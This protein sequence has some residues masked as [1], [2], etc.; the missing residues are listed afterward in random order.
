MNILFYSHSNGFTGSDISLREIIKY[1]KQNSHNIFLCLPKSEN[2]SY[3]NSLGIK[4]NNILFLKPMIWHKSNQ[5]NIFKKYF[6]LLYIIFKTNGGYFYTVPKL[7]FFLLINKI[8]IVH[9]NS[10]VLIDG[11]IAAKILNIPHVQHIR[12][13]L[14]KK[15][16]PFSFP[17][18][19]KPQ[20]FKKI[21]NIL[22][23][24]IIF[25][26]NF[27]K[28]SA[29]NLFPKEKLTVIP[30]SF[31]D[32]LY[33]DRLI[34]T[35]VRVIGLVAN[36]TSPRKNHILFL[37]IANLAS[38]KNL[39]FKFIIFGK[40]PN[41]YNEYYFSLLEFIRINKLENYVSFAGQVTEL[42][43]IYGKIDVLVHTNH[44]ETF[45][46]IYIESM[47]FKVPVISVSSDAAIELIE[48]NINGVL[49]DS[50]DE[51]IFLDKILELK[52]HKQKYLKLIEEGYRFS[53]KYKSSLVNKEIIN[54][55]NKII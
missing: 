35:S 50:F 42:K 53:L 27:S 29:I 23:K 54:I 30:N 25:N 12:E 48:N 9:S 21:M 49:I 4:R 34:K 18:Q 15:E 38:R 43:N 36:I 10:F 45:G 28:N 6:E 24:K 39:D 31:P 37:K 51:N 11:V 32:E 33:N 40:L 52:N 55:Y 1:C 16:S 17:L 5:K 3:I 41:L 47:I 13:L 14:N 2:T 19:D 8:D 7:L 46:R 20:I 22:H 44:L 26:S